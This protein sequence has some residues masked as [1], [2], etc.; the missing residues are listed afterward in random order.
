M[1]NKLYQFVKALIL[2][3]NLRKRLSA[4]TILPL[5][6]TRFISMKDSKTTDR[7]ITIIEKLSANIIFNRFLICRINIISAFLVKCFVSK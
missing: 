1:V 6:F 5:T 7:L 3:C 2:K 4:T